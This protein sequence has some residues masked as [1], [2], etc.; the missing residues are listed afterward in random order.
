MYSVL[1]LS[2][3]IN[4]TTGKG[5]TKVDTPYSCHFFKY[6]RPTLAVSISDYKHAHY[7][8]GY[9]LE[10]YSKYVLHSVMN[11]YH[12]RHLEID[13]LHVVTWRT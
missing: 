4:K 2:G 13:K 1:N 3:W 8:V 12:G 5:K 10:E 6:R 9:S 7:I 11:M